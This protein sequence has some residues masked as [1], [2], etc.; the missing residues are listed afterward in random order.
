MSRQ[1]SPYIWGV[2]PGWGD[3]QWREVCYRKVLT[4]VVANRELIDGL[5]VAVQSPKVHVKEMAYL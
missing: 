1:T 2:S 5:E 3:V 4:A